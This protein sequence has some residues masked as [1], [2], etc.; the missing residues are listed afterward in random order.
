MYKVVGYYDDIYPMILGEFYTLE[1]A[2]QEKIK[3]LEV[4]NAVKIFHEG[5]E[6]K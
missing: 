5:E 4:F 3:A 6:A 2:K 1:E